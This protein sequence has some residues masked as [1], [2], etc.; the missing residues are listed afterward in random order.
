M[1][2]DA[3]GI[4]DGTRVL[5]FGRY[6]AGPFCAALLG[7]LG[8]D[9]IRVERIDGGEDRFV[10]PVTPD[11]SGAFFQQVGRNKR[12]LTLDPAKPEGR[13]IQRKLIASADVVV[14][15]LPPQTLQALGLDYESLKA[16]RPDIVLTSVTA[17]GSGGPWSR[18]IGFDGLAQA[19]SGN[20]HMSGTAGT[21]TR[22]F[23][24]YVDYGT[25][26]L[27]AFGTVAALLHRE[28]TGEG[29]HVEGALLRTA[30]TFM[31]SALLEEEQLALGREA[32][33]NRGQT[34]GP[35]DVLPT[36]D[37]FVMCAVIGQPQFERWCRMVGAEDLLD[38]SRFADDEARGNHGE[39]LSARM[40]EWCAKRTTE[41]A[42][43]EMERA[44]VPG[45]PVYAPRQVLE[46]PH[47][48]ATGF[49]EPVAYPGASKPLS[50]S[51]FPL[52]LS[53][54]PGRIRN[55]APKL[56]EHTDQIL[57]ELGYDPA[58]IADLR[59]RRI[60]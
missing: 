33:L 57:T 12:S 60:V 20:L 2:E 22:S 48:R 44:K 4:L 59:T 5:D 46:D 3:V 42:L 47:V 17:F 35:A 36:R 18:K 34:A 37:G 8:A 10:T 28:R 38:D 43:A 29:Q 41:E 6:I 13:E 51:A 54:T 16:I 58:A 26:S 1:G 7:D 11:G 50:L 45:G 19:M 23:T 24:P 56:G 30:L 14:A 9:V 15:N 53:A 49:L 55:R 31:N 21:P 27:C 40:A 25:A 39:L 52:A 32:T